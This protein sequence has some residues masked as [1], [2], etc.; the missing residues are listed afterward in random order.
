MRVI[1]ES[2]ITAGDIDEPSATSKH[3]LGALADFLVLELSRD[4][5]LLGESIT[6]LWALSGGAI[7]CKVAPTQ[8][9]LPSSAITPVK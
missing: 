9:I 3:W 6:T 4:L 1:S 5:A 8:E 7:C 2:I